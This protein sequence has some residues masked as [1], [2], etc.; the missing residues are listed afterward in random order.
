MKI[1]AEIQKISLAEIMSPSVGYLL[2]YPAGRLLLRHS[3]ALQLI[4]YLLRVGVKGVT[5]S[6]SCA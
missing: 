4:V 6:V 5:D 2:R 3:H 1:A